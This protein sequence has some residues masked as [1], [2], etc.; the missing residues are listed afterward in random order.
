MTR[1]R[2]IRQAWRR[3]DPELYAD[4]P[5]AAQRERQR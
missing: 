3:R 4:E 2:A 1:A 5:I